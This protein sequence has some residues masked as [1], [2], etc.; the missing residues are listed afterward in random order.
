MVFSVWPVMVCTLAASCPT[1]NPSGAVARASTAKDGV[2]AW[3]V[4]VVNEI[5]DK[6]LTLRICPW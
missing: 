4:R 5:K 3:L 1:V 6:L 2:H